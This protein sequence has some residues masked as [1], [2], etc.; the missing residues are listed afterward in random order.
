[1]GGS[2]A[3]KLAARAGV[4]KEAAESALTQSR[5]D[6]DRAYKLIKKISDEAAE[7]S[8][9]AAE[10][11]PEPPAAAATECLYGPAHCSPSGLA[12]YGI[13]RDA[14]TQDTIASA[15][16]N[17]VKVLPNDEN[18]QPWF[19]DLLQPF[20][21]Y[22]LPIT[23]KA[24]RFFADNGKSFNNDMF[25]LPEF[26]AQLTRVEEEYNSATKNFTWDISGRWGRHIGLDR[27][28]GTV[29]MPGSNTILIGFKPL[30]D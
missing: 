20:Q 14:N 11:E 2:P 25:E 19:Q 8:Q 10:P 27:G 9:E 29:G 22:R 12:V 4:D 21:V 7:E 30:G 5:N 6:P 15:L 28:A 24:E 23:E 13:V 1:M 18:V 16:G 26:D 17:W 3:T